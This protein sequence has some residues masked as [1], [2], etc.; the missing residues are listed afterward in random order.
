M[1]FKIA[2][3]GAGSIGFTR[4]LL[5]DL[6]AVP[7][8]N[9]IEVAFTDISSANLE[10][11]T[12]LCQR[13]IDENGLDIKIHSTLNRREAL[14]DAKYIFCVVRIGG[15]EA[16][17]LDVD[18]PLKYGIDQCVGDTLCAGG[19][20]YG[21]RG[22][23]EMLEIC[24]DIREV[25]AK[26]CLLLNYANP[27][28]MLTWACNKYGG[29][30]TIGLCHGVQ[31]GHR[32]IAMA[33]GLE[34]EE[35]DIICAG[36]NHQTWYISVKHKGEDLTGRMLE[37]FE[38]HPEFSKTEKVR[39]D[40]MRRFGFYSTES[41]GHLSEYVPW[42]RKRP[43]EINDWIDLGKWING[44]TGGYLRVCT[45]GR[46]W[47]KTDFPNWMKEPA[48]EYKQENRGEEHGSYIVEA[49]ETGRTYRGHFNVVNN[50][51]ITN[52]PDDAII[53]APGYVDRNGINMPVVGDLPLGCAAVC[54]VSISVQRLAVEAAVHGDDTLL[55]QAM[56]M[57][58][59]V[60]AVCNPKEIWQMTDEMLVAQEKWLPQFTESIKKAKERL[61]AGNLLPTKDYQGAARL[62]V[63]SIEEMAQNKEDARKNAAE[64]DK[65]KERPS[66]VK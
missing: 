64:S 47:F 62:K 45:E 65:A 35:V 24:K 1:S 8:F 44:E 31:G 19:I 36:I 49:L 32:Q 28:A 41:N 43:E 2:F 13:D 18:I 6:L 21:Q 37:A 27:M 58:P 40:M 4:G 25:A 14:R 7:E 5:R 55:R 29:V 46:N 17:Q 39:I 51:V 9:N 66:A 11:V 60:G 38:N 48:I 34:K 16:F 57:D 33:F 56:M 20:M 52:L 22:I 26:D 59:L 61:A 10:M 12:Q 30:N 63:K 42:Y 3:I 54:N 50:G 53:E 15:L 23:A